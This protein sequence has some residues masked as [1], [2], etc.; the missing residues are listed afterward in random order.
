MSFAKD[1]SACCK[2]LFYNEVH[3]VGDS[4]FVSLRR[5]TF[6]NAKD[7][8]HPESVI[9]LLK[10]YVDN[11]D[12][13]TAN[14]HCGVAF[15]ELQLCNLLTANKFEK[16]EVLRSTTVARKPSTTRRLKALNKMKD[17][18]NT[19]IVYSKITW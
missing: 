15:N 3:T 9:T 5:V 18:H 10:N 8:L 14:K 1:L 16:R 7:A 4:Q 6:Q 12:I 19:V 11:Y 2:L 13:Y 17:K